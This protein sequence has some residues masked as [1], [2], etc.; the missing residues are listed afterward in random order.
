MLANVIGWP[1]PPGSLPYAVALV[2]I[3]MTGLN[4]LL[5]SFLLPVQL[6]L[7]GSDS[8]SSISPPAD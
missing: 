5:A 8:E 7:G 1:W 3:L 6:L 4:A 2:L